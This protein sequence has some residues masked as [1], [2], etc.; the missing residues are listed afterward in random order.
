MIELLPDLPDGTLGFRFS[1]PVSR[2][3][4]VNVLLPPMTAAIE[5]G[6][7]VRLLL[8]VEEDFGWFEPGAFWEDL[9]FG[10][11]PARS[12]HKAWERMAVVSDAGWVRHAMGLFGWMVPGEARAFTRPELHQAKEWL[13]APA[14]AS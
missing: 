11:G 13:A 8:V 4:Y 12:H 6:R 3:E 14:P 5:G 10:V 9:K 2:D 1:G 7:G